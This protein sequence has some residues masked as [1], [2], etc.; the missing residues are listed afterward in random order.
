M[1][2]PEFSMP[3]DESR[4]PTAA[5]VAIRT[6]TLEEKNGKPKSERAQLARERLDQA[7]KIAKK[8]YEEVMAVPSEELDSNLDSMFGNLNPSDKTN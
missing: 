5:E 3:S 8:E 6:I 1:K 7:I 4:P 2:S